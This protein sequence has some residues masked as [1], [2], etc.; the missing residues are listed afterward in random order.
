MSPRPRHPKPDANQGE[1][2]ADLKQLGFFTQDVSPLARLGFDRLVWGWHGVLNIP[3]LLA[4][5]IK[6]PG[7]RMTRREREVQEMVLA[8]F[9][10]QAPYLVGWNTEDILDW[11]TRIG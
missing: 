10:P 4:V 8:K 5:E 1:I 2:A 6:A 9:G 3:L 11:F 7:G